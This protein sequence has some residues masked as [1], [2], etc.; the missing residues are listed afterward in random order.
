[1]RSLAGRVVLVTGSVALFAAEAAKRVAATTPLRRVATPA[2]VA[3]AVAYL[4]S[5]DA[6]F[7]TGTRTSVRAGSTRFEGGRHA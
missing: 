5:D 4:V 6:A 1:M 3:A 7:I 2:D